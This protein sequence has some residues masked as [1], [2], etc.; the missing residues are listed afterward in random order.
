M[1]GYACLNQNYSARLAGVRIFT[2]VYN[3]NGE[4]FRQWSGLPNRTQVLDVLRGRNPR[5]LVAQFDPAAVGATCCRAGLDSARQYRS[6]R[7]SLT[8]RNLINTRCTHHI[9]NARNAQVEHDARGE[10]HEFHR[11]IDVE[12]PLELTISCPAS[13]KP[14]PLPAVL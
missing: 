2:E 6:L 7:L 14:R 12:S 5:V 4:L 11:I 3:P 9:F 13:M 10:V 8:L 1:G